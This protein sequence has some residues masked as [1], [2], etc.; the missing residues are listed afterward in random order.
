MDNKLISLARAQMKRE[1]KAERVKLV[2]GTI[3]YSYDTYMLLQTMRKI[4]NR[5]EKVKKLHLL[6]D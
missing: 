1:G 5:L 4:L 6:Y 3:T 2:N